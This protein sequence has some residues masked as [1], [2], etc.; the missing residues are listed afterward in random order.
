VRRAEVKK[1]RPVPRRPGGGTVTP[2]NPHVSRCFSGANLR[3]M[4]MGLVLRLTACTAV[5]MLLLSDT[6]IAQVPQPS[7]PTETDLHAAYCTEVI[8][9]EI[10][11]VE[12]ALA[13]YPTFDTT[14]SATDTEPLRKA[15]AKVEANLRTI[16]AGLDTEK[17]I[18]NK[19]HLYLLPRLLYL[20]PL[21]LVG[22]Q[23]AAKDDLARIKSALSSCQNECP[24]SLESSALQTCS[25]ECTTRAMPDLAAVQKKLKSCQDLEWLPF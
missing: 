8:N 4:Y 24:A 12:A 19:L 21:G 23:T 14:P 15:K 2:G 25:T 17:A 20:D 11:M 22:A 10:G 18:L 9:T 5:S 3:G 1:Q 16:K 13:S 6:G 7:P